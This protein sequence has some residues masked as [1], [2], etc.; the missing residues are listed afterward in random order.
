MLKQSN[1]FVAVLLTALILA[2]CYGSDSPTTVSNGVI[3]GQIFDENTQAP[4]YRAYI[5]TEPPTE[6][7]TSNVNGN[8]SIYNVKPGIYTV[9]A[10]KAG[11]Y[12]NRVSV[13]A[14]SDKT[15]TAHI[16]IRKEKIDNNPPAEPVIIFPDE[17]SKIEDKMFTLYWTCEDPDGNNIS[18]D[19]YLSQSKPP[20]EIFTSGLQ[21]TS[22]IVD[23]LAD[24]SD[25]YCRVIAKDEFGATT[26]SRTV[27]FKVVYKTGKVNFENNNTNKYYPESLSKIAK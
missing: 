16:A 6:S 18:Y 12:S 19:I 21:D 11:Y 9:I 24:S 7:V 5:T 2:G 1:A 4:I 3:S 10:Q 13:R 20:A 23:N 26:E 27:G 22:V 8:F 15:T 25:Y 17:G 14:Q